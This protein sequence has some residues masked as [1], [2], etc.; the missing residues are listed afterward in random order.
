MCECIVESVELTLTLSVIDMISHVVIGIYKDSRRQSERDLLD[1]GAFRNEIMLV[2]PL[3]AK[4]FLPN[5]LCVLSI[6]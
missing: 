4:D 3:K 2:K 6:V 5:I 1:L